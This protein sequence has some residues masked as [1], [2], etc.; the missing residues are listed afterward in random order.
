MKLVIPTYD[1]FKAFAKRNKRIDPMDHIV[2]TASFLAQA[3]PSKVPFIIDDDRMGW[4][5]KEQALVLPEVDHALNILHEAW[6][7]FMAPSYMLAYNNFGLGSAAANFGLG[8]E[9]KRHGEEDLEEE[10]VCY[11]TIATA[12]KMRIPKEAIMKEM[13]Y[14]NLNDFFLKEKSDERQ[15][16]KDA[17]TIAKDRELERFGFSITYA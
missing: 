9:Y 7:Y 2:D 6:H 8:E 5:A 3:F 10:A 16:Y 15:Q 13:D 4:D 17:L 14:A 12:R 11:F 1:Q